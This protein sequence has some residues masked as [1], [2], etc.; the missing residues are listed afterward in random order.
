MAMRTK[1]KVRFLQQAAKI[2]RKSIK[3]LM[4]FKTSILIRFGWALGQL[5]ESQNQVF[6]VFFRCFFEANFERCSKSQK[7][8]HRLPPKGGG[9]RLA[10][11][12]LR[13]PG[14]RGGVGEGFILMY[15]RTVGPSTRPEAQGLGGYFT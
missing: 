12:Q 14:P 7:M 5:L 15:M 13:E 3:I 6:S 1:I 8:A 2:N 11:Q 9:G 4:F 10:R